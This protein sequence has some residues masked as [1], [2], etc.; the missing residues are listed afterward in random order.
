MKQKN[1][2]ILGSTG[3]I[4]TQTLEVIS[5]LTSEGFKPIALAAHSQIDLLEQQAD[6][7]QPQIIAVYDEQKALE[8][9]KRL[10]RQKIVAGIEG[11]KEVASL[12]EADIVVSAMSGSVGIEPT[13]SAL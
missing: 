2:V 8:L 3:S 12:Q 9:Q 11:L 4:G 13:L 1:V 7:W 6:K 5:H 10:P